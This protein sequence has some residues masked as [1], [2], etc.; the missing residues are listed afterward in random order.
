V[1]KRVSRHGDLFN[2]VVTLEQELPVA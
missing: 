1:K 2:E